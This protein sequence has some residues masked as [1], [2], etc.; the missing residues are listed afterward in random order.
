MID[1]SKNQKTD[2]FLRMSL[3]KVSRLGFVVLF[4]PILSLANSSCLEVIK[5]LYPEKN[6]QLEKKAEHIRSMDDLAEAV[7]T[8]LLFRE[9]QEELWLIYQNIYFPDPKNKKQ[10]IERVFELLDKHPELSKPTFREQLLSIQIRFYEIPESLSSFVKSFRNSFSK[11][12]NNLIRIEENLGFWMKVLDFEY[13]SE[14]LENLSKKEQVRKQKEQFRKY[15]HQI[16]GSGLIKALKALN[17]YE[18]ATVLTFYKSLNTEREK[19]LSGGEN[20]QALSQALLDLIHTAAF[21][22][23]VLLQKL[24]DEDPLVQLSSLEQS[25]EYR[26]HLSVELGFKNFKELQTSLGVDHPTGLTKNQELN[27]I[28]KKLAE[29]IK[30][31]PFVFKPTQAVR[32]RA[33]NLQESPFRGCIGG[34]CASRSY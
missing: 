9:G 6:Q 29:D 20:V 3:K 11:V 27:D 34:D 15:L 16:L 8:G 19:K 21:L 2:N 5:K 23:P 22:N 30:S 13:Q 4:F 7:T 12:K 31:M 14:E 17:N 18:E 10:G 25:L 26:E 24:K 28:I 33:L 32:L 1:S